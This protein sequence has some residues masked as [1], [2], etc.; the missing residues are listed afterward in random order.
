[1]PSLSKRVSRL[2]LLLG[3]SIASDPLHRRA[4]SIGVGTWYCFGVLHGPLLSG[5]CKPSMPSLSLRVSRLWLL[6]GGSIA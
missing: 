5:E 1:M 4:S 6:L 3:G 2:W